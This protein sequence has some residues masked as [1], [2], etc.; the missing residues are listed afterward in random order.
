MKRHRSVAGVLFVWICACCLPV[1]VAAQL[2]WRWT[3]VLHDEGLHQGVDC[4]DSLHCMIATIGGIGIESHV[5]MTTDGGF[6]WAK[7]LVDSGQKVP[8][9]W[10]MRYFDIEYPDPRHGFVAA[11][12]GSLYITSD[13]GLTWQRRQ[14]DTT[15][16][17][18]HEISM[19]DRLHGAVILG[20]PYRMKVTADGWQTWRDV[21]PRA[22]LPASRWDSAALNEARQ[23]GPHSIVGILRDSSGSSFIRSDDGGDSWWHVDEPVRDAYDMAA[24]ELTFIDTL[25]GW[26]VTRRRSPPRNVNV[27]RTWD[28][29]RTWTPLIDTLMG[30]RSGWQRLSFADSLR[31]LA[32]A[33]KEIFRTTDGGRTWTIDSADFGSKSADAIVYHR[34]HPGLAVS[35]ADA[36]YR[37]MLRPVAAVL[38]ETGDDDRVGLQAVPNPV[39]SGGGLRVKIPR[40]SSDAVVALYSMDG[41]RVLARRTSASGSAVD[42]DVGMVRSGTY[43]LC[44]VTSEEVLSTTLHV[45]R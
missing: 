9:K 7:V 26:G 6:T 32:P 4:A 18:V 5:S 27:I 25:N 29:G 41:N 45:L 13:R 30:R 8:F 38:P 20:H 21:P 24:L 3:S 31:G 22:Y 33:F 43:I 23:I 16:D 15:S 40:A 10:P 11:D 28:G 14:I 39:H 35:Y 19:F 37:Y 2:E 1:E 36:V 42:L 17:P 44:V 34:G 12:T